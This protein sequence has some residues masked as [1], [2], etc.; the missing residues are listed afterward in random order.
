VNLVTYKAKELRHY[1]R[2]FRLLNDFYRWHN[3]L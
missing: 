2:G 3:A 1:M